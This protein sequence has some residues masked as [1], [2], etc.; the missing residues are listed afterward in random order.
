AGLIERLAAAW[1]VPLRRLSIVGHSMGALVAR[2]AVHQG[3]QGAMPWTGKLAHI[4]C[5]GAPHTGAPLEMGA[6]LLSWAL[7]TMPD[8]APLGELLD[9]RSDGIKDLRHGYLHEE[10]WAAVKSADTIV[11]TD[12]GGSAAVVRTGKRPPALVPKGTRQHFFTATIARR[13]DGLIGRLLGDAL[14]TPASSGDPT[15]DAERHVAGG[16]HHFDL[17]QHDDVYQ[18]IRDWLRGLPATPAKP[19]TTRLRDWMRRR[20]A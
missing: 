2:S 11:A 6:H 17:L 15:V 20:S 3:V 1:P 18:R 16:M 5:L 13:H 10:E 4:V 7:R 12:S 14:V 19:V 9:L 8:T